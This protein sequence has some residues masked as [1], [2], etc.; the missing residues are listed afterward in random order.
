MSS[1][2]R[3]RLGL[4]LC[5]A[6]LGATPAAAADENG[7]RLATACIGCHRIDG[8]AYPDI[9]VIAGMDAATIA[10]AMRQ[11][12]SGERTGEIMNPIAARYDDEQIEALAEFFAGK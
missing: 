9:P 2:V 6:L 8:R 12:R 7:E 11:F 10:A 4:I 3:E 5:C 1:M